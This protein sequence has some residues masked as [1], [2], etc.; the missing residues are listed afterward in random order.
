[1]T[2]TATPSVR[3]ITRVFRSADAYQIESAA[4][5]YADAYDIA[6]ALAVKHGLTVDAVAAVIAVLSPMNSW[7]NNV[8]L[9]A[10]LIA[11]K[12]EIT[13]GGI[14]ANVAKANRIIK[15]EQPASV[16]GGQK[17]TNFYLSI[18]TRGE[19]GLTVDRHAFDIAVNT[20]HTDANRP[21]IGKRIYAEISAMYARAAV[22]LSKEYG[23]TI[24]AGQVQSVTWMVWRERYWAR[25]AWDSH[26]VSA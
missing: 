17:V 20:R 3:N 22:I 10:R 18:L 24:T 6:D 2:K 26:V 13:S 23:Q 8:N 21:G 4:Q 16:V 5:W 15:G 7:G 19:R 12:G 14:P 1:M 9:A 11:G 25:G